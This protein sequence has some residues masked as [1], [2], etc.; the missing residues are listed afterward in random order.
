MKHQH[1][2]WDLYPIILGFPN[3]RLTCKALKCLLQLTLEL[4]Q[5]L[6]AQNSPNRCQEWFWPSFSEAY[7]LRVEGNCTRKL[8]GRKGA[9][10]QWDQRWIPT[11]ERTEDY[12]CPNRW[13]SN[14]WIWWSMDEDIVT[15]AVMVAGITCG[16][17][18]LM[19]YIGLIFVLFYCSRIFE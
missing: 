16:I 6:W 11:F 10:I 1:I 12:C 4:R 18:S 13:D 7:W 9:E 3:L 8:E 2:F 15:H 17:M 19:A 14:Y 5:T